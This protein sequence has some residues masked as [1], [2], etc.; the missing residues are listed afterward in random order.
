MSQAHRII[1]T[2][3]EGN[4][5]VVIPSPEWKGTMQELQA[6]LQ[7]RGDMPAV[8]TPEIVPVTDIPSDRTLRNAWKRGE[9]GKK[10]GVNMVKGKEITH[11]RRRAKREAQLAPLDKEININMANQAAVAQ[12]ESQRQAIRNANAVI[13]TNIDAA[14][15]PEEL[16]A[17]IATEGL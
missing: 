8:D 3:T 1:Y 6:L 2:N 9:Q 16:L 10:I 12:I 5:A 7:S 15:T 13:Q 4:T 17:I 11:A 14:T